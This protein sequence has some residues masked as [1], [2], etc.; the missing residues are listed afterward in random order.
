[1]ASTGLGVYVW[2]DSTWLLLGR[3]FLYGVTPHG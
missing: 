3:V 1:M 2:S